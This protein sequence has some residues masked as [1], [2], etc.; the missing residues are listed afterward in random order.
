MNNFDEHIKNFLKR[1]GLKRLGTA[2]CL[3]LLIVIGGLIT[4]PAVFEI[5]LIPRHPLLVEAL[6]DITVNQQIVYTEWEGHSPREVDERV[7]QPLIVALYGTNGVKTIRSQSVPGRSFIFVIFE[8]NKPFY[9]ARSRITETLASLNPHS[10]PPGAHPQLGP[11]A[12][13]LGQAFWY[14]IEGQN[15]QGKPTGGWGLEQL[16]RTQEEYL[17]PSLLAVP[18]VAEVASIGGFVPNLSVELDPERMAEFD[19]TLSSVLKALREANID[20]GGRNLEINR[21]EYLIEMRSRISSVEALQQVPIISASGETHRLERIAEVRFSPA[22][23][24]G[25]LDYKGNEAVGGIVTVGYGENPVEVIRAVKKRLEELSPFLPEQ[26]T[27]DRDPTSLS[28]L[29]TVPIYDRTTLI[30]QNITQLFQTILNQ[31][32][33]AVIVIIFFV[34]RLGGAISIGLILPLSVLFSFFLM[35]LFNITVNIMSLAGIALAIG[36]LVDFGIVLFDAILKRRKN[37]PEE[38]IAESV[39]Q[40]TSSV[41]SSLLTAT[42]TTIVGFLPVFF[43]TG[44]SGRLFSPLAFTKTF[45]LIGAAVF[46]LL[47]LPVIF[48]WILKAKESQKRHGS[49]SLVEIFTILLLCLVLVINWQPLGQASSSVLNLIAVML[50]MSAGVAFFLFLLRLY[51]RLLRIALSHPR[52]FILLPLMIICLGI[53]SWLTIKKDYSAT[54][55]EGEFLYMPVTTPQVAINEA[56]TIL[57]DLDRAISSVP[58][59]DTVVGKLG[60]AESPLDPAPISMFEILIKYKPEFGHDTSG[61]RIRHWRSHIK[62][63]NDIWDEIV[64]VA[65]R[66]G[67]TTAPKLGPLQTRSLMLQTGIR[68]PYGYKIQGSSLESINIASEKIEAFLKQLPNVRAETVFAEKPVG[69]P[70]IELIPIRE[71]LA[72]YGVSMNQL[73]EII[74]NGVGGEA[75]T[76]IGTKGETTGGTIPIRVRYLPEHRNSSESLSRLLVRS[77]KGFNVPLGRIVEIVFRK[78]PEMIRTE[79]GFITNYVIFDLASHEKGLSSIEKVQ[80]ELEAS[81][82]NDDLKLPHGVS[83]RLSGNYEEEQKA[84]ADLLFIVPVTLLIVAVLLYLHFGSWALTAMAFVGVLISWSGGFIVY[85]IAAQPTVTQFLASIFPGFSVSNLGLGVSAWIGFIALFGLATDDG[86]LMGSNINKNIGRDFKG[87]YKERIELL[88]NAAEN[89]MRPAV[90]TTATTVLALIPVITVEGVGSEVLIPLSLPLFGGML[91][92]PIALLTLPVLYSLW[93]DRSSKSRSIKS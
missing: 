52:S 50:I 43:L 39:R 91:F 29:T 31:S 10:L 63:P 71:E 84:R 69:K 45:V 58:E 83:Y 59:I 33:I 48:G 22:P 9:W 66:P 37:V 11:D 93:L 72:R 23:R 85:A 73:L 46:T 15:R 30:S 25:V 18:G 64:K 67:V 47:L 3:I 51:P 36:Q 32:L 16:R 35:R 7:T 88:I 19:V 76:V 17:K 74:S 21:V 8:D 6:P 79:D 56:K 68:T 28:K 65:E 2:V 40:G 55:S 20:V 80:K 1:Y 41:S 12:T 5:P 90:M 38:S 13:A 24:R 81:L 60:R 26:L 75:L 49:F 86:V 70:Y 89:R 4:L 57:T 27:D 77:S 82:R 44:M 34:A 87:S 42:L 61:N 92:S 53:A 62:T 14:V 54:F 78:G